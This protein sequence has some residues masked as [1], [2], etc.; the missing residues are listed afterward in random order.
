MSLQTWSSKNFFCCCTFFWLFSKYS[1]RKSFKCCSC[2]STVISRRSDWLRYIYIWIFVVDSLSSL[3]ICS[4][5]VWIL[6]SLTSTLRLWSLSTCLSFWMWR[7]ACC[8]NSISSASRCVNWDCT[9]LSWISSYCFS[10]K[11]ESTSPFTTSFFSSSKSLFS[12][13][14]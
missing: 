9:R 7:L 10:L 4:W 8:L 14:L 6:V 1:S 11:Q 3:S 2:S 13:C 5:R 12:F